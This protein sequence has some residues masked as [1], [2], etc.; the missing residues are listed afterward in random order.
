[1]KSRAAA[2]RCAMLCARSCID[3]V[4][5]NLETATHEVSPASLCG[6]CGGEA[7]PSPTADVGEEIVCPGSARSFFLEPRGPYPHFYAPDS[8]LC[9]RFVHVARG[10]AFNYSR[11]AGWPAQVTSLLLSAACT[12]ELALVCAGTV[13]YTNNC[14]YGCNKTAVELVEA[15]EIKLSTERSASTAEH[16]HPLAEHPHPH[17]PCPIPLSLRSPSRKDTSA[18][19]EPTTLGT[20]SRAPDCRFVSL[21]LGVH[22]RTRVRRKISWTKSQLH[23]KLS[24]RMLPKPKRRPMQRWPS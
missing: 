4:L 18:A 22:R 21:R 12:Q 5:P 16:A 20:C 8:L 13:T 1:V 6:V 23:R 9:T 24:Q 10:S 3:R 14:L 19:P 17:V 2:P 11:V 7:R 15:N